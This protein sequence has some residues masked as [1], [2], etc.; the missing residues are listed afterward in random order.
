[1]NPMREYVKFEVMSLREPNKENIVCIGPR[2][3]MNLI[4]IVKDGRIEFMNN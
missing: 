4:A 3:F 1:M 2:G